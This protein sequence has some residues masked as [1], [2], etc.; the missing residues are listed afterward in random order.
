MATAVVHAAD[1]DLARQLH[2]AHLETFGGRWARPNRWQRR[3]ERCLSSLLGN[4]VLAAMLYCVAS[5]AALLRL[6]PDDTMDAVLS[7]EALVRALVLSS[8]PIYL[9]LQATTVIVSQQLLSMRSPLVC[10]HA[11]LGTAALALLGAT[12]PWTGTAALAVIGGWTVVFGILLKRMLT[13]GIEADFDEDA[14]AAAATTST[15]STR[16]VAFRARS[17]AP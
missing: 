15:W 14:V 16:R 2:R 13:A 6:R 5:A 10:M 3:A 17:P 7:H 8:A 4:A 1:V 9:V 11:S 12:P